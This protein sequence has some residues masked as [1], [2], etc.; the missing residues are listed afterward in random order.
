MVVRKPNSSISPSVGF[1]FLLSQHPLKG[2]ADLPFVEHDRITAKKV[3]KKVVALSME[4][5]SSQ[6]Q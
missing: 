2:T 1:Y 3:Q 6:H 5:Q 4:E